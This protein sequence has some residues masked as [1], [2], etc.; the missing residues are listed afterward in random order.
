[1]MAGLQGGRL[2]YFSA[3]S[4]KNCPSCISLRLNQH[5]NS[6]RRN[7]LS[8]PVCSATWPSTPITVEREQIIILTLR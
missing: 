4:R 1:M 7:A 2:V 5:S 6:G 3:N 8:L